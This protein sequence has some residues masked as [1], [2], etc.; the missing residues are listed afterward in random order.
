MRTSSAKSHDRSKRV[1]DLVGAVGGLIALSPLLVL[2]AALIRI[3]MGAP[4][5][6]RQGR[7]GRGG[8]VFVLFKFRTMKNKRDLNDNSEDEHRLTP[9]GRVLRQTSIDE[10]PE[11]WNVLRGDMSL[12]GP[13]PLLVDYLPLY[14]SEQARR[15]E[16]RPGMTGLAQVSGRNILSWEDRFKLDVWYVDNRSIRLDFLIMAQT[17]RKV[18]RMEGISGVGHAT[19]EP[20]RGRDSPGARSDSRSSNNHR[21]EYPVTE[22]VRKELAE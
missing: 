4:I 11:L 9:L 18:L 12:V 10:L 21:T 5:L 2:T 1:I 15:H 6:F 8:G 7:P 13:R 3:T 14:D 22:C 17:L 16:V 19:M 20:F